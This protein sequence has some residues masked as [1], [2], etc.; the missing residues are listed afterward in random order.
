MYGCRLAF[1][2]AG[3]SNCKVTTFHT[4]KIPDFSLNFLDEIV[5][6]MSNKCTRINPNSPLKSRMNMNYS[7]NTVQVSY[8]V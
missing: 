4:E 7:T 2:I 8:S 1:A 5:G 6:N 3:Q